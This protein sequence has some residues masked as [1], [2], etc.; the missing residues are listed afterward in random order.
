MVNE[1]LGTL[2]PDFAKLYSAIGRPSILPEHLLRA[3]SRR[4]AIDERTT[5][6]PGYEISQRKRKLV[7]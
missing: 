3:T 2:S 7:E 4:S 1:I 5:R 6:H